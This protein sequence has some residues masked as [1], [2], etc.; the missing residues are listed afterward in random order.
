M[1]PACV[2][3]KPISSLMS[4]DA[5]FPGRGLCCGVHIPPTLASL[6]LVEATQSRM[7]GA[8]ALQT[9]H[10]SAYGSRCSI[11]AKNT[12]RIVGLQHR[13]YIAMR[14]VAAFPT[15]LLVLLFMGIRS[16]EEAGFFG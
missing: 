10:R 3:N 16:R 9:L 1:S 5:E 15:P 12:S 14:A 6:G 13:P 7:S 11:V 4:V 8:V 2:D